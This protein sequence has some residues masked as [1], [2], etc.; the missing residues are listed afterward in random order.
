[1]MCSYDI[2]CKKKLK[3]YHISNNIIQQTH[4]VCY[5]FLACNI[6]PDARVE[7]K[8]TVAYFK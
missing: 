8:N 3:V 4:D 7:R 6:A 2:S 1:M 5:A